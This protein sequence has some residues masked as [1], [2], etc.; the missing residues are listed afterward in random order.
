MSVIFDGS[1]VMHALFELL[2]DLADL[3][4]SWR[5]SL[6][7]ML[8]ALVCWGLVSVLSNQNAQLSVC[9]PVALIGVFLSFRWQIRADSGA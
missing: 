4:L 6:G 7:L 1:R 9:L 5:I 8:T 2:F 3:L